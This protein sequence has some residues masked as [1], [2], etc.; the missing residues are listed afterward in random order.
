MIEEQH[1]Y[2]C[3]QQI[4]QQ[5]QNIQVLT[6]NITFWHCSVFLGRRDQA[7]SLVSLYPRIEEFKIWHYLELMNTFP[8]PEHEPLNRS[9]TWRIRTPRQTERL[10]RVS[11]KKLNFRSLKSHDKLQGNPW[12]KQADRKRG[13]SGSKPPSV[14][15][16]R[17]KH[18]IMSAI[19]AIDEVNAL[20]YSATAHR[21]NMLL[22]MLS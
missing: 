9:S 3:L 13:K 7:N 1:E 19:D 20:A 10:Q 14:P 12:C 4:P 22:W 2:K 17:S 21:D 5:N 8:L 6:K 11:K 18:S 15:E 16:H